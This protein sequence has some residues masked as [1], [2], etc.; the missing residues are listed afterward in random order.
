MST[1]AITREFLSIS[2]RISVSSSTIEVIFKFSKLSYAAPTCECLYDRMSV[3]IQKYKQTIEVGKMYPLKNTSLPI[4]GKRFSLFFFLFLLYSC[5]GQRPFFFAISILYLC[6]LYDLLPGRYIG[7]LFT[8][9]A[10]S[11]PQVS[12]YS[13]PTSTIELPLQYTPFLSYFS[14]YFIMACLCEIDGVFPMFQS[15]F[16][17]ICMHLYI[18]FVSAYLYATSQE[19]ASLETIQLS[20]ES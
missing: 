8:L 9:F 19:Y 1:R 16:L 3:G 13:S 12:D 17:H 6:S 5:V 4:Y 10:G 15:V 20:F 11:K 2:T 18:R 14:F 7:T